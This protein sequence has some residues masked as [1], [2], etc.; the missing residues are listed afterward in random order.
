MLA[1]VTIRGN[2]VE[3]AVGQSRGGKYFGQAECV[4][5]R[6]RIGFV[7]HGAAGNQGWG[8][9]Q[10]RR[11]QWRVP[12]HD[13]RN[14]ANRFTQDQTCSTLVL[15]TIFEWIRLAEGCVIAEQ[16]DR[17]LELNSVN[18]PEGGAIF[19]DDEITDFGPP[20]FKEFRRPPKNDAPFSR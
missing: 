19:V 2:D 12:G 5:R 13:C 10:N 6:G 3:D 16:F 18:E 15:T 14:H 17:R 8:H 4:Q 9:L 1:H 7:D 20:D 11:P